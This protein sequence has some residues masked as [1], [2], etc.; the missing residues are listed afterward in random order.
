MKMSTEKDIATGHFKALTGLMAKRLK[1][2][3]D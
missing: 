3:E 1:A 2:D